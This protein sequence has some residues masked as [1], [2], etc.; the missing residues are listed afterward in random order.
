[1]RS[2]RRCPTDGAGA[3]H[4]TPDASIA[5]LEW[6]NAHGHITH[7]LLICLAPTNP[8][9]NATWAQLAF[10]SQQTGD[11]GKSTGRWYGLFEQPVGAA[12]VNF[13][14]PL[15][16]RPRGIITEREV[17]IIPVPVFL[18]AEPRKGGSD[19]RLVGL[20]VRNPVGHGPALWR[21]LSAGTSRS[22]RD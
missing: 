11:M 18:A 8:S 7:L 15:E 10:Q 4:S 2:R 5:W 19:A 17:S 20:P 9:T 16:Y 12:K 1:M 21:A 22:D 3:A 13:A 14:T 6:V